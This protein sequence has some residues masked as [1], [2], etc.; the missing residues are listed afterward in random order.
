MFDTPIYECDP[1][2]NTVCTKEHCYINGGECHKTL[3]VM[4]RKDDTP[5]GYAEGNHEQTAGVTE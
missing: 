5:N 2:K 1:S 3:N 4:F